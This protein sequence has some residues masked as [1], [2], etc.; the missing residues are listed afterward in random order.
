MATIQSHT[1][2]PVEPAVHDSTFFV[3]LFDDN[4]LRR[5]QQCIKPINT[6]LFRRSPILSQ[7]SSLAASPV[8]EHGH[9]FDSDSELDHTDVNEDDC[10]VMADDEAQSEDELP[11][12]PRRRHSG[13]MSI[14]DEDLPFCYDREALQRDTAAH[15]ERHRQQLKALARGQDHPTTF[16]AHEQWDSEVDGPSMALWMPESHRSSMNCKRGRVERTRAAAV[17]VAPKDDTFLEHKDSSEIE[18]PMMALWGV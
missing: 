17:A 7:H 14:S 8:S 2:H 3:G 18:G 4:I 11:P 1:T 12:S 13:A 16:A 5:K 9:F 6:S 15:R 10:A